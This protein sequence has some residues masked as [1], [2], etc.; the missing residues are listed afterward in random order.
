MLITFILSIVMTIS[1]PIISELRG[2]DMP[3]DFLAIIILL[4]GV[5]MFLPSGGYLIAATK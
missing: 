2:K 5:A 3:D 4:I 1:A